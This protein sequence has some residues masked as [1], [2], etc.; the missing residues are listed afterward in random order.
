MGN[1]QAVQFHPEKSGGKYLLH[2]QHGLPYITLTRN[3]YGHILFQIG[4]VYIM[5]YRR[6]FSLFDMLH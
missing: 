1:V 2:Q 6:F 5:A 4:R 3:I